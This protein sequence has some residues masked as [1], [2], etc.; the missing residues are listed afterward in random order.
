MAGLVARWRDRATGRR[1]SRRCSDGAARTPSERVRSGAGPRRAGRRP[2]PIATRRRQRR[3]AR[4]TAPVP[5]EAAPPWRTRRRAAQRR[6]AGSSR[7]AGRAGGRPSRRAGR[8]EVNMASEPA[9]L[10]SAA[11]GGDEAGHIERG[12]ELTKPDQFRASHRAH[13][14]APCS[15]DTRRAPQIDRTVAP[16]RRPSIGR[17]TPA[18]PSRARCRRAKAG[19]ATSAVVHRPRA[20]RRA[21]SLIARENGCAIATTT[22]VIEVLITR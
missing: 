2:P 11:A 18:G 6:S 19:N 13:Q 7:A 10:R 17:R 1:R 8:D 20:A 14:R 12:R 16:A 15:V 4:R 3:V 21:T 5:H 22:P 9:A